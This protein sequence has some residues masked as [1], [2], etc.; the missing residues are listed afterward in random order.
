MSRPM[1]M[2]TNFSSVGGWFVD[3]V[4]THIKKAQYLST[5]YEEYGIEGGDTNKNYYM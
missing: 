1:K 4:F 5:F 2:L 3:M